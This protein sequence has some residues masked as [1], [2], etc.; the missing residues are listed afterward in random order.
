L[1]GAV[2]GKKHSAPK[3]GCMTAGLSMIWDTLDTFSGKT[4]VS[5]IKEPETKEKEQDNGHTSFDNGRNRNREVN[6][7]PQS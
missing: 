7:N 1:A 3:G 4:K 6:V 2:H 5:E